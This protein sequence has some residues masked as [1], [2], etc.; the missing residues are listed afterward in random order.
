MSE[1][2]YATLN[3]ENM[4][5]LDSAVVFDGPVKPES[6][7]RFVRDDGHLM[8]FAAVAGEAIGFASGTVIF[9][10]DKQPTLFINEVGVEEQ[11]RRRGIATH[12][13]R[14]LGDLA[15]QK[16]CHSAWVATEGDNAAARALYVSMGAQETGDVVVFDWDHDHDL[17]D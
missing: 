17:F 4:H 1:I 12:L 5:L 16:G 13:I 14:A 3:A 8:I 11:W 7:L 10:P 6:L 9:H 15:R 2:S